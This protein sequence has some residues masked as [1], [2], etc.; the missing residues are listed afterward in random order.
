MPNRREFFKTV[1]AATAG[2][3]VAGRGL[4]LRAQAPPTRR[5][6]TIGGQACASLMCTRNG[7]CR[8]GSRQGTPYEKRSGRPW[9]TL[10]SRSWK[11]SDRC[12]ALRQQFW[13]WEIKTRAR[14]P[15]AK[16]YETLLVSRQHPAVRRDGLGAAP[17]PELPRHAPGRCQAAWRTRC[18]GRRPREGESLT[19]RSTM[20]SGRA[21]GAA[22][23]F[24]HPN[25]SATHSAGTLTDA[26][27]AEHRRTPWRRLYSC[28][29]YFSGRHK[30]PSLVCGSHGG[31]TCSRTW[32]DRGGMPRRARTHHQEAPE[33]VMRSQ[34]CDSMVFSLKGSPL[35]AEWLVRWSSAPHALHWP[36][37]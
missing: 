26:A 27:G 25:G 12:A 35:G 20:C 8:S 21:A 14:T 5:Q 11:S 4:G 36:S 23:V 3:Y 13:W 1:A 17:F 37:R 16:T 32:P 2:A 34:I 33:R 15:I 30:F 29:G 6:V 7:T 18:D 22:S 31:G 10:D 28:R 19:L 24:M 9:L